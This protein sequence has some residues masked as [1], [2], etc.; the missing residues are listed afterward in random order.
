MSQVIPV[1]ALPNQTFQVQVA[2]QPCVIELRQL[3]YGLFM[4]LYVGNSLITADQICQN[5]NRIVRS[6][7]LGFIGDF[8]FLD[9]QGGSNPSDPV[10]TGLGTRFQLIYMEAS[11]LTSGG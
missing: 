7:Y 6:T 5:L 10:F 2:N 1:Q 9:T 8:C 4:T 3:A 11:D